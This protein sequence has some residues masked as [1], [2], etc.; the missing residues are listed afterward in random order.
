MARS[1][2]TDAL[3]AVIITNIW[4]GIP[5]SMAVFHSGLQALPTEIFEAAELDGAG[6]CAAF[7]AA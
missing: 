5:F 2:S 4:I 1:S 6:A 7:L 3:A